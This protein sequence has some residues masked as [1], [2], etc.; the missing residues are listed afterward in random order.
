MRTENE[1]QIFM[2]NLVFLRKE[3]QLSKKKEMANILGIR[4]QSLTQLEN[5]ELPPGLQVSVIFNACK[6]FGI[7]PQVLITQALEVENKLHI[8]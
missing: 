8:N 6:R 4:I 1:L 5:G 3:N 7:A 2:K